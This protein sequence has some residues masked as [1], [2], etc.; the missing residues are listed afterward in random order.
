MFSVSEQNEKS[1][2]N[3]L[4]AIVHMSTISVYEL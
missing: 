3:Y 2:I 1:L 4:Q